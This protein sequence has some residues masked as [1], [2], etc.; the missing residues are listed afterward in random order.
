MDIFGERV[1]S[2]DD[3]KTLRLTKL[4][5]RDRGGTLCHPECGH[6]EKQVLLTRVNKVNMS[7]V[8]YLNLFIVVWRMAFFRTTAAT[9]VMCLKLMKF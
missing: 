6:S 1:L 4:A 3:S 9:R 7:I 8:F 5:S 2:L